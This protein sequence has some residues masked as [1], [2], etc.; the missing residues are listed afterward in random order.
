MHQL[1]DLNT[2]LVDRMATQNCVERI[3]KV[4]HNRS[5]VTDAVICLSNFFCSS[6]DQIVIWAFQG[7][8]LPKALDILNTGITKDRTSILFGL[9]N[10]TGGTNKEH[11]SDVLQESY[12]MQ[13]ILNLTKHP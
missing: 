7:G 6:N 1:A 4:M 12:L 11:I 2:E 9:S 10:I 3:M 5:D 13:R 8:L